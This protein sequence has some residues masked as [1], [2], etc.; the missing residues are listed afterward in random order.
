MK[1]FW[2]LFA[3]TLAVL[4][5]PALSSAEKVIHEVQKG[6]TASGIAKQYGVTVESLGITDSKGWV[7]VG[8]KLTIFDTER[9]V[10]S[11]KKNFSSD[12]PFLWKVP[13]GD[14]FRG[15]DDVAFE[16]L[17]LSTVEIIELEKLIEAKSFDV[18]PICYGDRFEIMVFANIK[19]RENVIASW[20]KNKCQAARMYKLSSGKEV[21]MPFICRNW[22]VRVP[23]QPVPVKNDVP[24]TLDNGFPPALEGGLP[25]APPSAPEVGSN[26]GSNR[27]TIDIIMGT[28]AYEDA[29]NSGHTGGYVWIK[30]RG[31]VW[32]YDIDHD[33]ALDVGIAAFYAAGGGNDRGYDYDWNEF[34]AGPAFR[35]TG[36]GWDG[37]LD[38]MYGRLNNEG[39]V[40][41]YSSSQKDN[42]FI[43][44]VHYNDYHRRQQNELVFPKFE[45]NVEY[46]H[47]LKSSIDANWGGT[48][49]V[50]TPNDNNAAE[51][52]LTP[53]LYD[54][55]L[56]NGVTVSPLVD[57]GLGYENGDKTYARI[58]PGAA[59]SINDTDVLQVRAFGYKDML[60][61]DKSQ[62]S[63]FAITLDLGGVYK[64]YRRGQISSVDRS[65]L[66]PR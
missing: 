4:A 66:D 7:Y 3:I 8:Q 24:P 27:N 21:W 58:M 1:K 55:R 54:F 61:S 12:E 9:K 45:A 43:T 18:L 39:D 37:N 36:N 48:P 41:L 57:F 44:S 42:V 6:E 46:R 23:N 14:K 15:R 13:G 26:G 30:G 63:W 19:I 51:L 28:G 20:D 47:V 53:Y 11:A 56:D 38:L 65:E 49:L 25:P 29:H 62:I 10:S 5:M 22:S 50:E 34:V 31:F 52:T 64:V 16:K 17:N 33:L 59:V 60:E 35:L 2:Q 40:S 32:S